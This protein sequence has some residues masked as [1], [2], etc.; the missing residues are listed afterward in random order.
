MRFTDDQLRTFLLKSTE[1][2]RMED[3]ICFLS[4]ARVMQCTKKGTEVEEKYST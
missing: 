2:S 1:F 3:L 4:E